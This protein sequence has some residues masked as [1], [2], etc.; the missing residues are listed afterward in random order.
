MVTAC[1]VSP[2]QSLRLA[3][4]YIIH[5]L[6]PKHGETDCSYGDYTEL[7]LFVKLHSMG[8]DFITALL[9]ES[10]EFFSCLE[11]MLHLTYENRSF[12]Q[13][14]MWALEWV[15]MESMSEIDRI[16]FMQRVDLSFASS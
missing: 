10:V 4:P 12:I 15:S 13:S 5:W 14:G 16:Q 2:R 8:A 3:Q 9:L 7:C 11:G 1:I 6:L